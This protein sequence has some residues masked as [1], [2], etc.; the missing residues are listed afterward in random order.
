MLLYNNPSPEKSNVYSYIFGGKS[1]RASSTSSVASLV[2]QA[3]LVPWNVI[4]RNRAKI[5]RILSVEDVSVFK[6]YVP[7]DIIKSYS[8]LLQTCA[9]LVDKG[10][11]VPAQL[12]QKLNE[13]ENMPHYLVTEERQ[14]THFLR[15]NLLPKLPPPFITLH[16]DRHKYLC[17]Q[18]DQYATL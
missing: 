8:K 18:T 2:D 9:D 15:Y 12:I 3:K 11:R 17:V 1:K 13:V 10:E 7:L 4:L 14:L 5:K 16:D 6:S